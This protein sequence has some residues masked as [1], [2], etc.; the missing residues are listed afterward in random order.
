MKRKKIYNRFQINQIVFY[1]LCILLV[2]MLLVISYIFD[3]HNYTSI[4]NILLVSSTITMVVFIVGQTYLL[5]TK[6]QQKRKLKPSYQKEFLTLIVIV[7][8]GVLG[9]AI[10]F[11]YLGGLL[12][13]VPH[14]IIPLFLFA[15]LILF[16]IGQKYFNMNLLRR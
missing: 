11:I 9:I 2:P 14:V 16:I 8:F 15:Y 5:I 1:S 13:Y 10:L 7:A 4:N 12:F 6:E 3:L